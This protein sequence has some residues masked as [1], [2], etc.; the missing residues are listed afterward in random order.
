MD[1]HTTHPHIEDTARVG[2]GLGVGLR[3]SAATANMEADANNL[4]AQLLGS[5]QETT[6]RSKLRPKLDTEATDRLGVIGGDSQH[7]PGGGNAAGEQLARTHWQFQICQASQWE[8]VSLGVV[9][10]TGHFHELHLAIKC[11]HLDA[12][13]RRILDLRDLLAGVGIDN[14]AWIDSQRLNQLNF[15][16]EG[17]G[18]GQ[19]RQ[20]DELPLRFQLI[21][22]T[23]EPCVPRTPPTPSE[24]LSSPCLHSQSRFQG[25][26]AS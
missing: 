17:R 9:V 26:P 7:Q 3:V 1:L 23:A 11:H 16:L 19:C 15:R 5:L 22:R 18:R 10:T 2:D 14:S 24:R 8:R 20:S 21:V 25:M 12:M 4:Q 6:T 13:G